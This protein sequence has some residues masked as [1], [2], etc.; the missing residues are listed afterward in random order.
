MGEGEVLSRGGQVL[1]RGR[2]VLSRDGRCC[3]GGREVLFKGEGV[4][5]GGGVV[6][7]ERCCSPPSSDHVTYPM[8]H[9]VSPPPPQVEQTDACENIN[10]ATRAVKIQPTYLG[11]LKFLPLDIAEIVS[12]D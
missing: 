5:E 1:S 9:L 7:R 2:E 12:K 4:V 8:M 11:T 6:Q 3:P 10:F